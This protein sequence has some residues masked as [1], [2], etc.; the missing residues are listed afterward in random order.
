MASQL[1]IFQS[2]NNQFYLLLQLNMG[3][4]DSG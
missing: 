3:A 4:K 2:T 1:Q